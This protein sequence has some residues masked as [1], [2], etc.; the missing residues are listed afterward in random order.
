M[1]LSAVISLIRLL[2]GTAACGV[3]EAVL[4]AT[5][6]SLLPALC[7]PLSLLAPTALRPGE[8]LKKVRAFYYN[9]HVIHT[10]RSFI[11][12]NK[13]LVFHEAV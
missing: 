1:L 6:C 13:F 4:Q 10:P 12:G 5:F 7:L 11:K 8:E 3:C 2:C 9:P